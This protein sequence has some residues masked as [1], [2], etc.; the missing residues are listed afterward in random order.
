MAERTIVTVV[1]QSLDPILPTWIYVFTDMVANFL[2]LA[3]SESPEFD[4]NDRLCR[5]TISILGAGSCPV[6]EGISMLH[7]SIEIWS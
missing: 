7:F 1:D 6:V 4:I 5:L 3:P 2:C